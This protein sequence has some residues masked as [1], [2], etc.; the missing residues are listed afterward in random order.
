MTPQ[1][2]SGDD[3]DIERQDWL[4]SIDYIHR[5]Y[6]EAGGKDILRTLQSHI[7]AR[8]ISLNEATLNTPHRNTIPSAEEP[9]YSGNIELEPNLGKLIRQRLAF[10]RRHVAG[11][12]RS[13]LGS[14]FTSPPGS[15]AG[16]RR[17]QSPAGLAHCSAKTNAKEPTI[18][19]RSSTTGSPKPWTQ[20]TFGTP[21]RS[22]MS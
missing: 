6:G 14:T 2:Q 3:W 7:L 19:S 10:S 12:P 15:G 13:C 18:Y 1:S 11:Q 5:H 9:L 21:R 4:E 16:C 22:W 20:P 8:D 17:R